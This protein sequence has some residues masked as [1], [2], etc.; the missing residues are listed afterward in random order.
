MKILKAYRNEKD[1]NEFKAYGS[2]SPVVK[3]IKKLYGLDEIVLSPDYNEADYAAT[4]RNY[5]V[6]LTS[7]S[8]PHVP[9]ELADN[10]GNLKYIC[11]ITGSIGGWIDEAIVASPHITITNWGDAAGYGIAEGAVALLMTMLKDIPNFIDRARKD[12]DRPDKDERRV[13]TLFNTRVGI[14][15]MGYIGRR[16]A[17]YLRP[18]NPDIYAYDPY[19]DVMPEGVTKVNSID[20]LFSISQVIAIHAGVTPE[21]IGSITKEHLAMLPDGAVF[22]NTARG[23]IVDE[24]AL[25]A[26]IMS[27]RIRAGLDVMDQRLNPENADMP[28]ADDPVRF[29][30]NAVFTGH[31]IG[32][33]EWGRDPESLDYSD[34]NCL[35]NLERFSKGEPLQFVIDIDRYRKMT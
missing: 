5:D 23:R 6:L 15:G 21:T 25:L 34:L 26:E 31:H 12:M 18:F 14:Y 9:N 33:T 17:E 27:G 7:W 20:E 10:P 3:A 13:G 19:V 22:I 8:S 24:P 2:P 4:I 1:K 11:N 28:A 29:V 30:S 16:F 35:A 32:G